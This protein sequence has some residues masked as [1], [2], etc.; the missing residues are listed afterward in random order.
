MQVAAKADIAG[1][2]LGRLSY[3]DVSRSR[4]DGESDPFGSP[5]TTPIPPGGELPPVGISRAAAV[6]HA[7]PA[8]CVYPLTTMIHRNANECK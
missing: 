5:T 1:L 4:P 6:G 3:L 7:R 8:S 2:T